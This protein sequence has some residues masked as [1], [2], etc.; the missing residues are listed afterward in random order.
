MGSF[1]ET[2]IDPK[3]WP[4]AER[5]V[6]SNYPSNNCGTH[7]G[8]SFILVSKVAN[9]W[10][11]LRQQ[12]RL[13]DTKAHVEAWLAPEKC[14][15]KISH[16]L[17]NQKSGAGKFLVFVAVTTANAAKEWTSR[18]ERASL[19]SSATIHCVVT[20]SSYARVAWWHK[21]RL[22]G[23]WAFLWRRYYEQ[24]F[25]ESWTTGGKEK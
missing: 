6:P 1:P 5:R 18:K 16:C 11:H 4:I 14:A 23:D 21:E 7:L 3:H 2:S 24:N 25:S 13:G 8:S 17:H 10:V 20:Q 19:E 22:R 9:G 12:K 15:H